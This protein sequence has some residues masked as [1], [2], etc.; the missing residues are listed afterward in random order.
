MASYIF[1]TGEIKQY[2][3]PTHL[4][5]LI[6]D[7]SEARGSEV[8]IVEIEPDQSTPSHQHDDMEQIF[9]ILS[10]RG[11]LKIGEEEKQYPLQ[12]GNV[13]RIPV[14]TLHTI[15]CTGKISLRYLAVDCF[16]EGLPDEEPTWDDHVKQV[17]RNMGWDYEQV[18]SQAD[19][20]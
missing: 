20:N 5:Y 12:P 17:C 1:D 7:R 13:V 4:N 15:S 3:F 8:F 2:R 14:A 16:L 19:E 6:M 10:G 18:I 11:Y 9:Y